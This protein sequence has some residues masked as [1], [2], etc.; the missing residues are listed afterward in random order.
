[1]NEISAFVSEYGGIV[2]FAIVFA[3]QIGLPIPAIP[4]LLAAGALAGAGQMDL[5]VAILLSI[6]ACLAGDVVWYELGRRR[7]RQALSL[8]CRISLEPDFC[9]R[10]T[11][12]FF[13]RHGIRALILAKFLPGLSTLAP[14]MAGLF[15]VRFPRFLGY[16]GLGAGLWAL[17]FVLPGYVFSDEIEAIAAQQ[18]RAGLFFLVALGIG[19]VAYI[20]YKF[21]HR[22]WVLR[23]LRM[24]RMTVDELKGM[25]D[26]GHDVFVV[27]LRGALDH[28]ADPFTI[29][30]ALRMTAEE[31]EKRHSDIPRHRDVILFCACPN[32]ATAAQ[33]ALLLRRNGITKVR[34][35]AGGINAWRERNF[36]LEAHTVV[37]PTG[38]LAE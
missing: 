14:A 12:N 13:T 19:L 27:D 3:E 25:M 20:A 36:P 32:E 29:P 8:L 24:A 34:P 22:Q 10:R 21:A 5:S 2:L 33:M 17:T 35:L 6:A 38:L 9:V 4:V 30:G 16:D 11:E 37:A 15:G 31:I 26:N 1:M 18:S 28:E 7:G 23:E